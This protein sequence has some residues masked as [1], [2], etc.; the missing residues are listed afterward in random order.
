MTV[1]D[2]L[3]KR[4]IPVGVSHVECYGDSVW[5]TWS[6]E[7]SGT[8]YDVLLS[9]LAPGAFGRFGDQV[10]AICGTPGIQRVAFLSPSAGQYLA[11]D[12]VQGHLNTT[13]G[14]PFSTTDI[15]LLTVMLATLLGRVPIPP[16]ERFELHPDDTPFTLPGDIAD[17][18]DAP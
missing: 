2:D 17:W 16:D 18:L 8:R 14:K 13:R 3:R 11:A 10:V 9:P 4:F 6:P 5:A 1:L 15:C 7:S 12:Y